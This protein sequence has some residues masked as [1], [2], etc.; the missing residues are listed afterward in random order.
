[1]PLIYDITNA[2]FKF[3][4]GDKFYTV[5]YHFAVKMWYVFP[6]ED[7]QGALYWKKLNKPPREKDICLDSADTILNEYIMSDKYENKPKA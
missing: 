4:V 5:E 1:M 6:N 3:Y 2:R 7:T